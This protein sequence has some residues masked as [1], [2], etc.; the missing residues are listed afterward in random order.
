MRIKVSI[1]EYPQSTL[2]SH[3][4]S[5]DREDTIYQIHVPKPMHSASLIWGL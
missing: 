2:L 1:T 4:Y 5:E 3:L